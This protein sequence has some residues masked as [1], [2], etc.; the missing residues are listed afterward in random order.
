MDR[1]HFLH[2]ALQCG[3]LRFGDFRLKSGRASPYFFDL[4]AF[5][6]GAGLALLGDCC[7]G[8]VERVQRQGGLR[9]ELLFGA[10]YKGIPLLTAAALSLHRRQINLPWA[11]NRKEPKRHGEGGGMVG[12]P[13]QGRRALILDDVLTAGT[14]VR[15]AAAALHGEGA[16]PVGL[17]VMLDRRE[18]GASGKLA[19]QELEEECHIPV[20]ALATLDDLFVLLSEPE[21][22]QAL[23]R[24]R[25]QYSA[26]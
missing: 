2:H 4:G 25:Q 7:A 11:F 13:L 8:L 16:E 5:A 23:Q 22:V 20:F 21:Q 12:A 17:A 6:D 24:Y 19:A 14:A 15:A 3:A 10:A 18:R 9:F 26:D 1:D